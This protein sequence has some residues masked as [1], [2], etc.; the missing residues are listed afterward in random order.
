MYCTM[1][2]CLKCVHAGVFVTVTLSVFGD[3]AFRLQCKDFW[4]SGNHPNDNR[5][6]FSWAF[7]F[8]SCILSFVSAGFIVWLA[9]LKARDDI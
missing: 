4:L 6:S 9:V 8:V 2:V 1:R 3:N 5:L 7:E